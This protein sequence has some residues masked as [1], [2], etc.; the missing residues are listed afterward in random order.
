[1]SN[2]NLN[3][4]DI[5]GGHHLAFTSGEH[6]AGIN[7]VGIP[8]EGDIVT[9]ATAIAHAF[10]DKIGGK[11]ETLYSEAKGLIS[12]A[13]HLIADKAEAVAE[14]PAPTGAVTVDTTPK[15][16]APKAK[17]KAK[18]KA[19]P[20]AKPVA[21]AEPAPETPAAVPATSE[22]APEVKS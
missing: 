12:K 22:V 7:T 9:H 2:L 8:T 17:A 18:P 10:V 1:M 6:S 11:F 19:K 21:K 16:A 13:F 3:V 20:A 4:T 15:P 14:A 5:N